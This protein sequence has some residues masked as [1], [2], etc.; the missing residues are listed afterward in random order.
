[1]AEERNG[2]T[3]FDYYMENVNRLLADQHFR[4]VL[5]ELGEGKK[6]TLSLLASD[7]AAFLRYR[8]VQIPQD[9]RVSFKKT[10]KDAATHEPVTR[11]EFEQKARPGPGGDVIIICDCI[12]VC[13]LRYC[14]ILCSCEI[15]DNL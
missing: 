12:E 1:M 11:A 15:F 9:F 14:T 6:E 5:R 3:A 4:A 8:G 7:P 2:K 13:F 10:F